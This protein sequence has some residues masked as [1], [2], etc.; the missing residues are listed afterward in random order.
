M[1]RK[2]GLFAVFTLFCSVVAAQ[3]TPPIQLSAGPN[4]PPIAGVSPGAQDHPAT[5]FTLAASGAA[6]FQALTIQNKGTAGATEF[7]LLSL[8]KDNNADGLVDNGD[9][10]ITTF[11]SG[12]FPV[13]STFTNPVQLGLTAAPDVFLVSINVSTGAT[14]G[15]RLHS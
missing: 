2:L 11:A 8:Y 3:V 13:S 1:M 14:P 6:T 5:Q 15:R 10:L 12:S 9:T 4:M 7:D